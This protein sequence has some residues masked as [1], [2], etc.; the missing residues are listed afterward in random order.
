MKYDV[1]ADPMQFS[2]VYP[3]SAEQQCMETSIFEML[4]S[5]VIRSW[6]TPRSVSTTGFATF[7]FDQAIL[8][9]YHYSCSD[10]TSNIFAKERT[11]SIVIDVCMLCDYTPHND[12]LGQSGEEENKLDK[13][14]ND[15]HVCKVKIKVK[16]A[17]RC[18]KFNAYCL[19]SCR[20]HATMIYLPLP[21][22]C[23][24]ASR[25]RST[26]Q[27]WAY[28]AS[29]STFMSSLNVIASIYCLRSCKLQVVK[30]ETHLRT[31]TR[32]VYLKILKC[33]LRLCKQIV[34]PTSFC[35]QL[36]VNWE[37]CFIWQLI[38]TKWRASVV[39]KLRLLSGHQKLA[40]K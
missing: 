4:L 23:D 1:R 35:R 13:P 19:H 10:A 22:H 31:Q 2:R 14:Y 11:T 8:K 37:H 9:D 15:I 40:R 21:T 6:V 30:F 27:A 20:E 28:R 3:N 36:S 16:M 29:M 18:S 25:S 26:K 38:M 7:P 33:R 32:V 5:G 39:V 34:S 17:Y 12:V 24:L